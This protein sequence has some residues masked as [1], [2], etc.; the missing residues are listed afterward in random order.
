MS[1]IGKIEV[2]PFKI[3]DTVNHKKFGIGKVITINNNNTLSIEFITGL[4]TVSY[5]PELF[6]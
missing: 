4:K 3:G 5:K 1:K 2:S 6:N